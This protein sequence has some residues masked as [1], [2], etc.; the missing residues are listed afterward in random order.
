VIVSVTLNPAVY[1]D[2]KAEAVRLGAANQIAQVRHRVGGR[3]LAVARLLHTF[4]HDVTAAG[5]AGGSAGE[6]IRAALAMTGVVTSFTRIGGESRRVLQIQ[7]LSAGQTT[8]FREP[9]PYITTEEL[10]R[11]AADYRALLDGA[12]AVVLCGSLPIGLPAETYG[13]LTSYADEAGVPVVLN[14]SGSPLVHG[15]ARGP[16]L[17]IPEQASEAAGLETR[18]A[19]SVVLA[20][21]RD[22]QVRT[23]DGQWRAEFGTDAVQVARFATSAE[24]EL[25]EFRDGLV[26]GFVPGIALGW[27]WPDMLRHALALAASVSSGGEVDLAAYEALLPEVTITGPRSA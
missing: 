17:V 8:S 26:A 25:D 20:T 4:G 19:S 14:A 13:S 1:V 16:A 9:A 23:P 12:T 2:Y 10:G 11:L 24:S 27:S 21:D 22:V 18:S 5:L 6:L 15:A 7:D 3:G